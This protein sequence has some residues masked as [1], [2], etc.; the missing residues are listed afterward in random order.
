LQAFAEY[1]G[2]N[3]ESSAK[4]SAQ[5]CAQ[6]SW[7]ASFMLDLAIDIGFQAALAPIVGNAEGLYSFMDKSGKPYVGRSIDLARRLA[8]HLRAGRI[9]LDSPISVRRLDNIAK[10]ALGNAEQLAIQGCNGG[11]AVGEG[12]NTLANKINAINQARRTELGKLTD[13]LDDYLSGIGF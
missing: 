4:N 7:T 10:E 13:D 1:G 2:V 9:S 5:V 12:A 11:R 6:G 8:E 3:S